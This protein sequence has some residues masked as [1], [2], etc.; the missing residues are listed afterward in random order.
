MKKQVATWERAATERM[1]H[2]LQCAHAWGVDDKRVGERC[3]VHL[4]RALGLT[5]GLLEV[6]LFFIKN[7]Q[8]EVV[9]LRNQ[10]EALGNKQWKGRKG[11]ERK[12]EIWRPYLLFYFCKARNNKQG[13]TLRAKCSIGIMWYYELFNV[14]WSLVIK[15]LVCEKKD[16]EFLFLQ[17]ANVD[18]DVFC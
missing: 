11:K 16:F 5:E 10:T 1:K 12:E 3:A 4:G 7:F 8:T 13:C 15:S 17:E 14:W 6:S 18:C 2:K 9:C